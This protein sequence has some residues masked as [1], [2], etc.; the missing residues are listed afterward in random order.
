[1]GVKN[2]NLLPLQDPIDTPN[3]L[4][5]DGSLERDRDDREASPERSAVKLALARTCDDNMMAPRA[6]VEGLS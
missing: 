4:K 3:R 1:M 2:L 6:E 5:I